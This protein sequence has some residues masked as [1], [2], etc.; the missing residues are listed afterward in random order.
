MNILHIVDKMD[1]ERGG[2]CQAIRT[3][4]EGLS[5]MD[6]QNEVLCLDDPAEDFIKKDT[7]KT[8]ALGPSTN[9]W[10]YSS[11]LKPWLGRHLPE[12]DIIISHGLWQYPGYAGFKAWRK[13]KTKYKLESKFYVMPHGMLDP[14]FQNAASRKLKAIRNTLYWRFIESRIVNQADGVLFTCAEEERLA[15][16]PFDPYSPKQTFVVGLGVQ[17]PPLFTSSMTAALLE[18]YPQFKERPYILFLSRIHEKKGADLLIKAYANLFRRSSG[19]R[20]VVFPMLM[21]AGPG[22][23]TPYGRQL[24]QLLKKEKLPEEA[25]RFVG[26]LE[27]ELKWGAFYH[28]EAFILPSH[29]ENYGIA[30]VEALACGKPV[31]I[32]NQVNIWKEI[33]TAG[34]AL[35]ADINLEGIETILS[36]WIELSESDRSKM[37]KMARNT[38]LEYF[39]VSSA[40]QKLAKAIIN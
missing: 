18:K 38:F 27:G 10:T 23:D 21:I 34:A 28:C 29:Q 4:I 17:A 12:F 24:R 35:V 2:V 13:V 3:I 32:S 5:V 1:P 33:A 39:T 26:M 11:K 15:A 40:T 31:L 25:I 19:N 8:H 7:F 16:K 9:R 6:I 22:L 36:Q 14:Y 37:G 30:V 20:D